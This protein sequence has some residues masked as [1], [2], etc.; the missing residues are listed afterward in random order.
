MSHAHFSCKKLVLEQPNFQY[1]SLSKM[2]VEVCGSENADCRENGLQFQD[3]L[4]QL[5]KN[6]C[7]LEHNEGHPNL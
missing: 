3:A 1:S 6:V 7:Q 5:E 2:R 4:G